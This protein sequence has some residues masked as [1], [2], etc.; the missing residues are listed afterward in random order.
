MQIVLLMHQKCG[1]ICSS[2]ILLGEFLCDFYDRFDFI[3]I[4]ASRLIGWEGSLS[5]I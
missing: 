3:V 1:P 5:L 2:I 4:V